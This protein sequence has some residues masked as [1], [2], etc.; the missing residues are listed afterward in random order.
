MAWEASPAAVLVPSL[1]QPPVVQHS[2][3]TAR[4]VRIPARAQSA[5]NCQGPR[6]WPNQA[7]AAR[8]EAKMAVEPSFRRTGCRWTN[9]MDCRCRRRLDLAHSDLE[10]GQLA[11]TMESGCRH[12]TDYHRRVEKRKE[13]LDQSPEAPDQIAV[14]QTEVA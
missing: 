10:Q 13:L 12:A 14:A 3:L 8:K 7:R 5:E 2:L 4:E 11:L 9:A 1:L 6:V